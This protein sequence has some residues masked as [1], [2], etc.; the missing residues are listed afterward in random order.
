M[1]IRYIQ[2]RLPCPLPPPTIP[3]HPEYATIPGNAA[4]ASG[5]H[6]GRNPT[7]DAGNTVATDEPP[8]NVVVAA[9]DWNAARGAGDTIATDEPPGNAI[10]ASDQRPDAPESMIAIAAFRADAW[11]REDPRLPDDFAALTPEWRWEYALRTD[12]ARRHGPRPDPRRT[13]DHL[14]RPVPRHAPVRSRHLVRRQRPH[15][16][17]PLQGP[18]RHRPP[19]Q[20]RQ[21]R[22]QLHPPHPGPHSGTSPPGFPR[23]F[24]TTG[25]Q[26]PRRPKPASPSA[27]RTSA[28][29]P[30]APSS[31]SASPTTPSPVARSNE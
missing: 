29:S 4:V 3:D 17:H 11:I 27:G 9:S 16:L 22:H 8:G 5:M 25:R 15:R 14:P 24:T 30:K 12:Y 13:P 23:R 26:V 31:P 7:R 21:G 1:A 10:A 18:P 28:T 2:M 6:S 20:G 19:P